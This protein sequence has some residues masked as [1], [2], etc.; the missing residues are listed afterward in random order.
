MTQIDRSTLFRTA[1]R[2]A[3]AAAAARGVSVRS[4]LAEALGRAWDAMKAAARAAAA[5]AAETA[6]MIASIRASKAAGVRFGTS[7]PWRY[8]NAGA[9]AW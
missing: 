1:W 5:L 3:R 8:V 9:V 6:A 7:K 4:V 2:N